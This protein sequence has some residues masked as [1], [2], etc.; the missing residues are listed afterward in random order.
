V[1]SVV[2]VLGSGFSKHVGGPLLN[3]LLTPRGRSLVAARFQ[4]GGD[5]YPEVSEIYQQHLGSNGAQLWNNAEEFLDLIDQARTT[6]GLGHLLTKHR[7]GDYRPLSMQFLWEG[8]C[9]AVADECRFCDHAYLRGEEAWRPYKNWAT[10]L[11]D[12]DSIITFN[13]DRVLET[14]GL[15]APLPS[16]ELANGQ[17]YGKGVYKL[18]GSVDWAVDRDIPANTEINESMIV[19]RSGRDHTPFLATPGPTKF[20][21]TKDEGPLSSLW[22]AAAQVLLIADTVVFIGYRFPP[23]DSHALSSIL[24]AV[25]Q[26]RKPKLRLLTVL[27]PD[28]RHPDTVRLEQLLLRTMNATG[29]DVEPDNAHESGM[30]IEDG[31]RF[32]RLRVLPLYA[33]DYMATFNR[34]EVS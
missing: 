20:N 25:V 26:N 23:S 11:S 17:L 8:A 33:Q 1:A 34:W 19:R 31:R 22:S 18:H 7:S 6:E 5:F 10:G 4:D 14:L 15:T 12:G 9:R 28:V 2:W 3:E 13:Y 16:K 21:H 32:Y 24:G 29:R 30:A 27:G